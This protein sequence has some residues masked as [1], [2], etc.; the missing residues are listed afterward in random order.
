MSTL[1]LRHRARQ[2]WPDSRHNQRAWVRSVLRLG[3]QW[4]LHPSRP[5]VNWGLK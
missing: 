1:H 5:S 4:I 3:N 2:L